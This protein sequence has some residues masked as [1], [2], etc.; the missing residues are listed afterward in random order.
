MF[1]FIPFQKFRSKWSFFTV[2]AFFLQYVCD[3]ETDCKPKNPSVS[4]IIPMVCERK[5][6]PPRKT[7]TCQLWPFFFLLVF[8]FLFPLV[9]CLSGIFVSQLRCEV[10]FSTARN[11]I[12]VCCDCG[13][14]SFENPTLL[15]K[16]L[17]KD[18][19]SLISVVR[20]GLT[21]TAGLSQ[22]A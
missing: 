2:E 3:T 15:W 12:I 17:I 21:R 16:M 9:S 5:K 10:F 19:L 11:P 22:F 6:L 20:C 18:A 4:K 14:L 1:L 13:A 7:S 8:L